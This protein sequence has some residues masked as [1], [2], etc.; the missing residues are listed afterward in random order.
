MMSS[1]SLDYYKVAL[2]VVAGDQ[3]LELYLFHR[4]LDL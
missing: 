1:I 2:T 3:L 4:L